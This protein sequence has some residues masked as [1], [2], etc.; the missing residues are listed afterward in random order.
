MNVFVTGATGNIGGTVAKKLKARGHNIIGLARSEQA[1]QKLQAQGMEVHHGDLSNLAS[2]TEGVKKADAVVHAAA[3]G[4]NVSV[5][6]MMSMIVDAQTALLESLYDTDKALVGTSG[7]GAYGDTG[8]KIVDENDPLDSSPMMGGFAKGEAA[9]LGAAERGVRS[10]L[11]RPAIVYGGTGS[12]PITGLIHFAQQLGA[13]PM[14]GKGDNE[15]AMVHVE[16][17]ADLYALAL[18]DS[19]G[20]EVYNGVAEPFVKLADLAKAI[21]HAIG[22]E[23][24]VKSMTPHEIRELM[25]P[26]LGHF[27]IDNVRVSGNKAKGVLGWNPTHPSLL[28]IL[29]DNS[30]TMPTIN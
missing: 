13:A 26:F 29:R 23:G 3:P 30:E 21:S 14:M 27:V 20:G 25:G 22:L 24:K 4:R 19:E 28:D 5:E 2:L 16:D 7:V 9:I 15:I 10:V 1:A 17:L 8:D 11:I 12:G 6:Q 18:E